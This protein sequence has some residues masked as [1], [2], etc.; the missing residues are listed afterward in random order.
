MLR[1]TNNIEAYYARREYHIGSKTMMCIDAG[2]FCV[3]VPVAVS[4]ASALGLGKVARK[5]WG[6]C[7]RRK[8][9]TV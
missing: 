2:V 5:V 3:G 6:Y 4:I 7:K 9:G 8:H 1:L